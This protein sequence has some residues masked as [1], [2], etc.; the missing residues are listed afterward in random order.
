MAKKSTPSPKSLLLYAA[1]GLPVLYWIYLYLTCETQVRW[2]SLNYQDLGEMIKNQ[3]WVQFFKTGPNREP[4]YPFIISLAMR[5]AECMHVHYLKV[6]IVIQFG[7]L[8]LTQIF[9]LKILQKLDIAPILSALI[10]F[11]IGSSPALINCTLCLYSEIL[12]I[13]L[14]PIAIWGV[15]GIFNNIANYT[16]KRNLIFNG[17]LLGII[18]ITLTLVK[19]IFEVAAPAIMLS[20]LLL[21]IKS[22]W[23]K[24]YFIIILI[25][26][27][28][29]WAVLFAY[30]A[31]NKHF[32]NNFVL[33][34]RGAW[35]FYGYAARRVEPMSKERVLAGLAYIPG[36]GVCKKFLPEKECFFWSIYGSDSFG[37][38]KLNELI[39]KGFK[40]PLLDKELL[41]LS[42]QKITTAPLQ[43]SFF[44]GLESL[45]VFFWE[46][47]Q[48]SFV[49]YPNW[50]MKLYEITFLKDLL[51]LFWAG[52]SLAGLI[53][54]LILLFIIVKG[55]KTPLT[56]EQ[57]IIFFIILSTIFFY[58]AVYSLFL[59]GTRYA[60]PLAP[61]FLYL[62]ASL[63]QRI[64]Y[65]P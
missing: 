47:T 7:L 57:Q 12:I 31:T 22:P 11:Y 40:G 54:S 64:Y 60:V 33:T 2:D 6:L 32:N 55:K 38:G 29:F 26:L 13:A 58:T 63:A 10:V 37:M 16:K 20:L 48:L 52:L 3:G 44:T 45:K 34:D 24:R 17:A 9:S 35:A 18:F 59:L 46:S 36:E 21:C 14:I 53:Y 23:V 28:S 49:I 62:I 39:A 25:G 51:R 19:G 15:S 1:F 8:F 27:L 4:L 65:K 61:L 30:K 43:Y 5:I 56:R 42:L 50:L 41:H